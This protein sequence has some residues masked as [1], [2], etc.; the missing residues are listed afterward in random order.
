[1]TVEGNEGAI[2]ATSGWTLVDGNTATKVFLYDQTITFPTTTREGYEIVNWNTKADGTGDEF[3]TS[4]VLSEDTTVY[5]I[6]G[7]ETYTVTFNGNGG[8]P[9]VASK[10]VSYNSTYGTLPT[11]TKTGYSLSGWFTSSTGGTQITADT[12]VTSTSNHTLYAQWTAGTFTISYQP[13]NV[14]E[15]TLTGTVADQVA[16]YGQSLDITSSVFTRQG[17]S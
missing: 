14:G 6:W 5:A 2:S 8:T 11:A 7:T 13:N 10:Q 1:M 3:S 16:T 4:S 9:S 12:I 15:G 17:S